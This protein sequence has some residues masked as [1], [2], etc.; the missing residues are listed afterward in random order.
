MLCN[1]QEIEISRRQARQNIKEVG[2]RSADYGWIKTSSK[3]FVV[4]KSEMISSESSSFGWSDRGEK[5]KISVISLLP[6]KTT[7]IKWFTVIL[8]K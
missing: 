7:R 1:K 3:V 2:I 6:H 5:S 4:S 8:R